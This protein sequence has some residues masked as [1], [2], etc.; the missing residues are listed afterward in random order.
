M[1]LQRIGQGF[2]PPP[3]H[4]FRSI[5]PRPV[6]AMRNYS[7]LFRPGATVLLAGAVAL[8][9]C[10][11]GTAIPPEKALTMPVAEAAG[12]QLSGAAL[13]RWMVASKTAPGR[14]EASGLISAW[15]NDALLI[16]AFRHNLPLDDQLTFDSV[17]LE[18]AKRV[19]STHYFAV[20]DSQLPPITERQID[21]VLDIDQA[22]VF[23]QIVLRVKGKADTAAI[24]AV[25]LRART[26]H[27]K[28]VQG[29]DFTAA[30]KEFSDDTLTK[31]HNGF[32]TAITATDA[33]KLGGRLAPLFTLAPNAISPIIPSPFEPALLIFRR[34]TRAESRT[35]VKAWLAPIL[36]RRADIAFVDSRGTGQEDRP[37][38]R[39]PRPHAHDGGRARQ[40]DQ[41][42][43]LRHVGR[44]DTQ[45]CGSTHRDACRSRQRSAL[46]LTTLQT[47]LCRNI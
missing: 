24:R 29:G 12:G 20:R 16:D 36:A 44:R 25:A 26:L 11:G 38:T 28:L 4:Q 6:V 40:R 47:P 13:D 33:A 10:G 1:R 23:Q 2:D 34:A 7:V 8:A 35:G 46:A 22:R 30:V 21:S 9:G 3:L 27:D 5:H 42:R 19:A 39:R 43:T 31:A 37:G 45:P 32:L 14:A 18:T 15:L 17:I 41:H